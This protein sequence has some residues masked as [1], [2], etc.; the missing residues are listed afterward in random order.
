MRINDP[1]FK[2]RVVV[3]NEKPSRLH[4]IW[5]LIII[6]IITIIGGL[7]YLF[8]KTT[9]F[10]KVESKPEPKIILE[11]T[12]P[13]AKVEEKTEIEEQQLE[14]LSDEVQFLLIQ[15]KEQIKRRRLTNEKTNSAYV[16]YKKIVAIAPN[17]TATINLYNDIINSLLAR[18]ERQ[19][20]KQKYTTPVN[21]NALNTYRKIL[22]IAPNNT[23]AQ[24]G[25]IEIAN[26][27]YKLAI[28]K[29]QQKKY[30]SSLFW[31]EKGLEV[32]A[33]DIKLIKLKQE[34]TEHIT[35]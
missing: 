12:I 20:N 24:N 6:L 31:I 16:I 30:K 8:P 34:V 14:Q 2:N 23:K 4:W 28:K 19:M 10:K 25:I 13:I 3:G 1:V 26:T 9:Q 32:I 7:I 18:A 22:K 5:F 15:A 35:Q 21:N 11:P 27:Y 33:D 17:A 29:Q